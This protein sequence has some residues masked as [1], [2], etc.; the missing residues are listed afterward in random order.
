[1]KFAY[2]LVCFAFASSFP[3]ISA[4]EVSLNVEKAVVI[5]FPSQDGRAYKLLGAE[6]A[7]GPWR[8]L[9]DGIGGTGGEV[10]VF[11]KSQTDQKLFFKVET[12]EGSPARQSFLSVARL[13]LS[14]QN[15]AGQQF[16]GEDLKLF[17]L[18][19]TVFENANLRGANLSGAS[20]TGANFAGADLRGVVTDESTTFS[21][22]TF[23]GANLE[24]TRFQVARLEN[25]DFRG[26][27]LGGAVIYTSAAN[28]DF[29]SAVLNGATFVFASLSGANFSGQILSNVTFHY[30][31]FYFADLSG[32]NLAGADLSRCYLRNTKLEG[33]ILTN[34]NLEGAISEGVSFAGRDLRGSL[35]RG[36]VVRSDWSRIN[37]AGVDAS[38]LS[39]SFF[40]GYGGDL[41]GANFSGGN[42][43]GAM[44]MGTG[45]EGANL[46]NAKLQGADLTGAN[47]KN[48]DLTGADFSF[49]DLSGANLTGATGFNA[50][51]PGIRYGTGATGAGGYYGSGG[52][53][54]A[55]VLPDGTTRSGRNPGTGLARTTIPAKL[56]FNINDT[57]TTAT[58]E[59]T[60]TG[61]V[62]SEPGESGG[63]F[64]YVAKDN[65]ATL[66]LPHPSG[67]GFLY[68]TLLFTSATDG[69]LFKNARNGT[70]GVFQ[71]GT[72]NVIQ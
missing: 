17:T 48:A 53:T 43:E 63:A 69:K 28:S 18:N 67:F 34:A 45:F 6:S 25:A 72:F 16:P 12:A 39:M 55:T 59:L 44:L 71:I 57:G 1:M 56:R 27:K 7:N 36:M 22:A 37:A 8:S 26:A 35:L 68:Y 20:A 29:R 51:Q 66:G 5:T 46:R 23:Y 19:G 13:N 31:D 24:G 65:L 10:T 41:A 52:G 49:V 11:Y 70:A 58:R 3:W 38:L 15:F 47:L 62:Y 32:A 54:Q 14:G 64:T 40:F 4:E 9:Q 50:E 42:L 33:A 60:F 2:S 21:G 30:C 61:D